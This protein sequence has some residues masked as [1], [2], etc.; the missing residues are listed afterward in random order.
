M[1][2]APDFILADAVAALCRQVGRLQTAA[3]RGAR[4]PGGLVVARK[5]DGSLCS[6][7]DLQSEAMLRAGLADLLPQAGFLGEESGL[8]GGDDL[9]WVVDPLDG[10]T[11][12]VSGLEPFA[13]S[14]ALV[15]DGTAQL[16]VVYSPTRAECFAAVRG[17]G[18]R[19]N[20]QALAQVVQRPLSAALVG[21]GLPVRGSAP[22]PGAVLGLIDRLWSS[23]RD[24][25]AAGCA[26]LESSWVA[27]GY[28]QGFWETGLGAWDTAAASVLLAETGCRIGDGH[29]APYR[30]LASRGLLAGHPGVFEALAEIVGGIDP[31]DAA[32]P[33]PDFDAS[34]CGR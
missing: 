18:A 33:R 11:N 22:S 28:L 7:I 10:T 6:P 26:A 31:G 19:R 2:S 4:G 27:A 5:P 34:G 3:F 14:V 15:R 13:V 30:P 21:I 32:E 25:R 29:G 20:G 17:Y 8:S 9:L 16:G 1:T 24:L 23:A 12:F